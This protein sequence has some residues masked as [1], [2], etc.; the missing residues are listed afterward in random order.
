MHSVHV[1]RWAAQIAQV[2]FEIRHLDDFLHLLQNAFLASANHEFALVG[3]DGAE[4]AAAETATMKVH[5]E[6]DH[7]IRRNRFPFV[8]RMRQTRIRQVESRIQF[9]GSHQREGGFTTTYLPST[10]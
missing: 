4:R 7:L 1:G 3:R 9:L 10:S 8:F 6:L 5:G 2:S